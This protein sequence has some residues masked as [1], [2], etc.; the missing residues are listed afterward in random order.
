M[1]RISSFDV[2]HTILKEGIYISRIDGD[3]V[4]YD[5]RVCRPN[6]GVLM[7][8][9]TMHTEEH[10]FATYIRN[11]GISDDVIYFGP[12]GCQTGF[13]LL[14]RDCVSQEKLLEVIKDTLKKIIAHDGEVFGCSAVECGNYKTLHL[15]NAKKVSETYLNIIKDTTKILTY[16]DVK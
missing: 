5:M 2:D 15:E 11:S 8:N 16:N 14:V 7:D 10:M 1:K 6:T 3:V 12:M 13:Y 4:T 9:S